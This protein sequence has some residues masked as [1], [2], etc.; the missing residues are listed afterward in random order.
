MALLISRVVK[1][2]VI[3]W[4]AE[5]AKG[6][7]N[8]AKDMASID[9]S[10]VGDGPGK[11][12]QGFV[13]VETWVPSQETAKSADEVRDDVVVNSAEERSRSPKSLADL[14]EPQWVRLFDKEEADC[15]LCWRL[16]SSPP[17]DLVDAKKR[18]QSTDLCLCKPADL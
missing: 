16:I 7:V 12:V 14:E 11:L 2:L 1:V 13:V 17:I 8:K 4:S 15:K 6:A 9:S 3:C 5:L 10:L 18:R